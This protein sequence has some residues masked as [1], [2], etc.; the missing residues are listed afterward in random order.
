MPIGLA[1]AALLALSSRGSLVPKRLSDAPNMA[2]QFR[3]SNHTPSLGTV[4]LADGLRL[5]WVNDGIKLTGAP[6]RRCEE[7]P[8]TCCGY[9]ET[10]T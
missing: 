8:Q 4:Q 7:S 5:Q 3:R 9:C 6:P 1:V 2:D 10:S